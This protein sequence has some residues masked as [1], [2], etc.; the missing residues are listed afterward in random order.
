MSFAEIFNTSIILQIRTV[1]QNGPQNEI[2]DISSNQQ[3]NKKERKKERRRKKLS[4]NQEKK[5]YTRCKWKNLL[6]LLLSE[7]MWKK[8]GEQNYKK[9]S[10]L[11]I[12]RSTH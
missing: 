11:P 9:K 10:Q 12:T 6:E 3:K 5:N 8:I 1:L 7:N 4:E 2:S